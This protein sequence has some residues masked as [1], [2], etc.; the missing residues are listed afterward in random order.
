M[1]RTKMLKVKKKRTKLSFL[2]LAN[3]ITC[4]F[5]FKKKNNF[6]A[7]QYLQPKVSPC[8]CSYGIISVFLSTARRLTICVCVQVCV[9]HIKP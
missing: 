9:Y 6:E 8:D 1:E 7:F 3:F 5:L 2:S 4:F